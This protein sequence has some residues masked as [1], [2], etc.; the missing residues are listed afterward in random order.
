M[1]GR[2]LYIKAVKDNQLANMDSCDVVHGRF[3]MQGAVDSAQ[4][5]MLYMG[6]NSLMPMVLEGADLSVEIS[7]AKCKVSGSPL[8]DKLFSFLEKK[9][10]LENDLNELSH[11]ESQMIMNGIDP[12]V[13]DNKLSAEAERILKEEDELLTAFIT[14]N[15]DN[16][17]S[18]GLFQYIT[19]SYEYPQMTPWIES[20][21]MKATPYFKE[22]PYVK[23]YL[24]DAELNRKRMEVQP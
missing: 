21:V 8:N 10:R 23:A 12:A 14:E 13:I 2:K 7:Q 19:S 6:D 17:L 4:I 16:I 15:F 1:D 11:K 18:V 3:H 9:T 20:I 5:V 24:A 22:N